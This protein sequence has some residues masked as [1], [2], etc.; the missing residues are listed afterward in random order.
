[1]PDWSIS[2]L[3]PMLSVNATHLCS[4]APLR[5]STTTYACCVP[6]PE[7]VGLGVVAVAAG[8][9]EDPQAAVKSASIALA[10]ARCLRTS[11]PPG[12][13]LPHR[14]RCV[15]ADRQELSVPLRADGLPTSGIQV[16]W[17]ADPR[18]GPAFPGPHPVASIRLRAPRSQLRDSSG[19]WTGFPWYPKRS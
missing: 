18:P 15:K 12:G 16:S 13:L 10:M 17:L 1:M 2:C 7:Q 4:D 14:T 3:P 9:D 5:C 6:V 8:D 11:L 19:F